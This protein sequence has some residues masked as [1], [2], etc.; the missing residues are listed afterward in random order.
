MVFPLC[1]AASEG[2]CFNAMRTISPTRTQ[3]LTTQKKPF[4]ELPAVFR[5]NKSV[6]NRNFFAFLLIDY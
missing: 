3:M 6:N 1:L 2:S 5:V 4:E